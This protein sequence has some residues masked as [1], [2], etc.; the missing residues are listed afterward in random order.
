MHVRAPVGASP[1]PVWRRIDHVRWCTGG[2]TTFCIHL[3]GYDPGSTPRYRRR[4]GAP[5]DHS[6][7]HDRWGCA[8]SII[9]FSTWVGCPNCRFIAFYQCFYILSCNW[10]AAFIVVSFIFQTFVVCGRP[11]PLS[12]HVS[13]KP[14]VLKKDFY[15]APRSHLTLRSPFHRHFRP[16]SRYS[17]CAGAPRH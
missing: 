7:S 10:C 9:T 11:T 12:I 15:V 13:G 1:P 5:P 16:F 8:P 4:F 17:W 3:Q 6:L 14:I 2:L